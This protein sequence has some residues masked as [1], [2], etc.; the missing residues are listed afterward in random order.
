MQWSTRLPVV[1]GDVV[2]DL[3]D[4]I[5]PVAVLVGGDVGLV[6]VPADV[7]GGGVLTVVEKAIK[8]VV[9]FFTWLKFTN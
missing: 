9:I 4:T 1:P 5:P 2:E 3:G 8:T 6:G 7:Q